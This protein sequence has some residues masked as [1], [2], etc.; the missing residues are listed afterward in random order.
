MPRVLV[1]CNGGS[2]ERAARLLGK[3]RKGEQILGFVEY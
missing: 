3:L 1:R 2:I